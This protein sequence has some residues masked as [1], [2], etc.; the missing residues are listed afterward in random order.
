M[1][2]LDFYI[3]K[4]KIEKLSYERYAYP[5]PMVQKRIFA[6]YLK[7]TLGWNNSIIGHTNLT[8][9]NG[10]GNLKIRK[11]YMQNIMTNQII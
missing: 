4:S 7:T 8:L 3:S 1:P 6:V 2:T 9:S 10:C 11:L 5:D